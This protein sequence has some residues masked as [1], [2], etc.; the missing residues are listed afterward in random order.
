[1]SA[2]TM[3]APPPPAP[4]AGRGGGPGALHTPGFAHYAA[5]WSPFHPGRLALASAANFGLVGNG[6]LHIAARAQAGALRL[7]KWCA[8]R[9]DSGAVGGVALTLA[10]ARDRF[11]TQDALFD[12]AWS[13]THENQ[14]VTAGGDGALRLWDVTLDVRQVPVPEGDAEPAQR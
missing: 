5:A 14:L 6:R 11:E 8:A 1:M 10:S 12:L 2:L 7:D 13:E 4:G 9:C 3:T